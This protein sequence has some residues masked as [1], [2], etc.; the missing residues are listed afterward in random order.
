MMR[1]GANQRGRRRMFR[2]V[3]GLG[4]VVV[5]GLLLSGCPDPGDL[6][7]DNC[8]G[9]SICRSYVLFWPQDQ[10]QDDLKVTWSDKGKHEVND[11]L[12][13]HI[14]YQ[15][16][17]ARDIKYFG[18]W[19]EKALP[20][21]LTRGYIDREKKQIVLSLLMAHSCEDCR[22]DSAPELDDQKR[23]FRGIVTHYFH[24][25]LG[26][27][28]EDRNIQARDL[29]P[30]DWLPGQSAEEEYTLVV[31][32]R[33]DSCL[34]PGMIKTFTRI[35]TQLT[36]QSVDSVLAAE[37]RGEFT[38]ESIDKELKELGFSR[39][40]YPIGSV[41]V[42]AKGPPE[43]KADHLGGNL[44]IFPDET[45]IAILLHTFGQLQTIRATRPNG[46]VVEVDASGTVRF[47]SREGAQVTSTSKPIPNGG[48]TVYTFSEGSVV[49]V[50]SA[51]S[52]SQVFDRAVI[53]FVDG[54]VLTLP[55]NIREESPTIN[56]TSTTPA[57]AAPA[58]R[59]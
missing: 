57:P 50:Y 9:E 2:L 19:G 55:S 54:T 28:R 23:S 27:V 30:K 38:D 31:R 49:T 53:R 52:T 58:S 59:R 34:N 18:Q 8:Y 44:A 11:P 37:K 33:E 56:Y 17:G 22:P 20:S 13:L 41:K 25:E 21:K 6:D 26:Q 48:G 29:L 47:F 12:E 46:K 1:H 24:P 4:M 39:Y 43:I 45:R 40:F 42:V 10:E 36:Y 32:C 51:G 7:G 5:S 35:Q 3:Q 16:K 14:Y 15:I